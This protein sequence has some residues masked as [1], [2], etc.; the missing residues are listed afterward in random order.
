VIVY[1]LSDNFAT[2]LTL[3]FSAQV[4]QLGLCIIVG[5]LSYV[6]MLFLLGIRLADL[7]V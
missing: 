3:S 1:A 7:K 5:G 6:A 4:L 2:W